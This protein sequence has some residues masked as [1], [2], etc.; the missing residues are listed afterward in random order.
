MSGTAQA[1]LAG[2]GFT[3]E[4]AGAT[5]LARVA[6][7]LGAPASAS[8]SAEPVPV[9][10][11][12]EEPPRKKRRSKWGGDDA[13]DAPADADD[14]EQ[15]PP[16][17]AAV[18]APPVSGAALAPGPLA[19]GPLQP[20]AVP[21]TA[22][23]LPLPGPDVAGSSPAA[24]AP[25]PASTLALPGPESG[26]V[27]A[28]ASSMAALMTPAN[29]A[30]MLSAI[31]A[32]KGTATVQELAAAM[33]AATAKTASSQYPKTEP[34]EEVKEEP[35][36]DEDNLQAKY[37]SS[38]WK[39]QQSGLRLGTRERKWY[40]RQRIWDD[41]RWSKGTEALMAFEEVEL[42]PN[43]RELARKVLGDQSRYPARIT[44]DTDVIVEITAWG[45]IL[46]RPRG[47]GANL[48][49]AKQM[50]Y[51]VLHP[52]G[53][54]LREEVLIKEDEEV[55]AAIRD[56]STIGSA[57]AVSGSKQLA[58]ASERNTA[59]GA[60]L[61]RVGLGADVAAAAAAQAVTV[62]IPLPTPEDVD[63]V[64]RHVANIR[65]ATAAS[66]V[67]KDATLTIT[68]KEDGVQ[69]AEQL[70]RTLLE[71]GQWV[72][73]A[74]SFVLSEETK[75]KRREQDGPSEQI[76]IKVPEGAATQLILKHLKA[77]E[78]AAEADQLRMTSK[79][80]A[81]KRSLMVDGSRKAHERVKLMVKELCEKG[82]SPMLSKALGVGR[83]TSNQPTTDMF[84][85]QVV[86]AATPKKKALPP[87]AVEKAS[88]GGGGGG[89]SSSSAT[90]GVISKGFVPSVASEQ[91]KE[92]GAEGMALAGP[93][94]APV[95]NTAGRKAVMKHF[96]A[97]VAGAK[98]EAVAFDPELPVGAAAGETVDLTD[99]PEAESPGT[100]LQAVP[101]LPKFPPEP[102]SEGA[103]GAEAEAGAA[104]FPPLPP[105]LDA[106]MD[107]FAGAALPAPSLP[108][109]GTVA[110]LSGLASAALTPK[111]GASFPP[112]P[113][114]AA[115]QG[116][117]EMAELAAFAGA[118]DK[119]MGQDL[120]QAV[121]PGITE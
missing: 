59:T 29:A 22:S 96:E 97:L 89:S 107:M 85:G 13:A 58:Q 14:S 56:H 94:D 23:G 15:G 90:P 120:P 4:A 105:S 7:L 33:A 92:E 35:R 54:N 16:A 86:M 73:F 52:K 41:W 1:L 63:L 87:G 45:T 24:P 55:E 20:G 3:P 34:K 40:P 104:P 6:A 98:P 74:E 118:S 64:R 36:D 49:L 111:A 38:D 53:D 106:S 113:P 60:K 117:A 68:G 115:G 119:E 108:A 103:P 21:G 69:R 67:L 65:A 31:A 5:T 114:G 88:D 18:V 102:P 32:L 25:A 8:E 27:A 62:V 91:P 100:E 39:D 71:T 76:L 51:R 121:L 26:S 37:V 116:D 109:A 93:G 77:M 48:L 81:G 10:A 101:G 42:P 44:D 70:L 11:P 12:D 78:R 19:V 72:A 84:V 95:V 83:L 28:A 80:V 112:L 66:A 43:L 50:V 17:P 57:D 61:K 75:E 9:A 2:Q 110:P 30:V 99:G 82:Q 47:S 46:L 79:P